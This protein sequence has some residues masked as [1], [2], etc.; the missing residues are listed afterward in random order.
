MSLLSIPRQG[1]LEGFAPL[2]AIRTLAKLPGTGTIAQALRPHTDIGAATSQGVKYQRIDKVQARGIDGRGITIGALS[3]SYDTSLTDVFGNPLTIHAAQDIASGDLPGAGNAR[4]PQ[5][6]QVIQD[7]D[8]GF[9]EGRGMLQIA[10]DVAPA[11]KLCFATAN[12][13]EV[14][15]ANNIRQL[16]DKSGPCGADVIVDDVSYYTEPFFSD[17]IVGDAVDDVAA[18]GVSYFTSAGNEGDRNSW[19]APVKLVP[20][21]SGAPGSNLDMSQ[22]PA[23]LWDGGL[24]DMNPGAGVDV[25][26]D[27]AVGAGGGE[28]DFQWDDPFDL[29]GPQLG[30]PYFTASGEITTA[31][32][33]PTFTFT[34][35]A[36][37]VGQRVRFFADGVPSGSTDLMLSVTAPDGTVLADDIDTGTSPEFLI[38]TLDQAGPYTITIRG[39]NGATGPFTL[40]VRPVLAPTKV[41]TDF[42]VLLFDMDGNFLTALADDN[43]LTG[44]PSEIAD[45][46]VLAEF[47]FSEV[48]VAFSRSGTG[49]I[50]ARTMKYIAFGDFQIAEYA[51]P[52]TPTIFAHHLAKGAISV[53]AYDPFRPNLPEFFTSPGGRMPITFDSAGNRYRTPEIRTVPVLASTDGGN[54]TFFT[55]DTSRDPDTQPNFFGTSAAAP[56][57]ASIAALLLQKSGG[58]RSL[59]PAKVRQRLQQ[60][61]YTHDLDPNVSSGTAGGLTIVARGNQGAEND[62]L[63]GSMTDPKFFDV[64][65]TGS[66]PLKSITFYGET[67][68][69]TALG[70]RHP[71]L[72]DGIVFDPRPFTGPSPWR[73]VG[74]PFTVGGT[75]GGLS[76]SA[77]T[78]AFSAPATGGQ[79]VA[80]Q[81]RHMTVNFKTGLKKGN[82]VQFGVDRDLAA[83]GIAG[84]SSEG[85]G[86]DELGGATLAP[87]RLTIPFGMAFSAKRADGRTITG[88]MVNR[89]GHGWTPLDGYGVIDAERAVLGR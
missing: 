83:P 17:G 82:S 51:D 55:S 4:Y 87:Q 61:T 33:E 28:F 24:Q 67:A 1:T 76:P 35:T 6:V 70:V 26:Q 60:S 81:Y 19:Q 45:L 14:G 47:G 36:A 77:V 66:V 29:N 39:F 23:A 48:Q 37:Q 21:S 72:S 52:M 78:A 43:T 58:P 89:L 62:T 38:T 32:P 71:P 10:H 59:T 88:V 2:S 54:T 74:F 30:D 8:Q 64:R 56:H 73:T 63:P 15:F 86:A 42:N 3:D 41:T 49:P 46:S 18:R 68:S 84:Q 44:R 11:A 13:G 75:S 85:N 20:A 9:D 22:V 53:A 16:A 79:S 12:N 27:L 34:A 31:N 80:G 25:A 50:S 57:A 7:S 40:D 65:Y 5:P 69:P